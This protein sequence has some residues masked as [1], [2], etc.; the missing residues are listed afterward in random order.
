MRVL[1]DWDTVK[2]YKWLDFLNDGSVMGI[3][4]NLW[5]TLQGCE[6]KPRG[7]GFYS[8]GGFSVY[9]GGKC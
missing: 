9:N 8:I 6:C 2:T 3:P 5:K 1:K 7:V 4:E